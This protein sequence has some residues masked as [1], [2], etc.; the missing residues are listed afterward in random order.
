L[1]IK[2][3]KSN[4]NLFNLR[5][6]HVDGVEEIFAADVG[7]D[8][9]DVGQSV[10]KRSLLRANDDLKERKKKSSFKIKVLIELSTVSCRWKIP[11]VPAKKI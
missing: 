1:S 10:I 11:N 3:T 7:R 2:K 9:V 8:V 4:L 5:D 6:S